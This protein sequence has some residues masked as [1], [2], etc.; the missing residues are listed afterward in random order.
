MADRGVS[1]MA[2]ALLRRPRRPGAAG[3]ARVRTWRSARSEA[4]WERLAPAS[5]D[6]RLLARRLVVS[7]NKTDPGAVAFDILRTRLLKVCRDNG[8][9]RV[10]ITSPTKGM[11]KSVICANLAFALARSEETRAVLLDLDLRM[12]GLKRIFGLRTPRPIAGLLRGEVPPEQFLERL[13]PAVAIGLNTTPVRHSSELLQ[14][15]AAR[16][17]LAAIEAT[18]EP[19]LMLFDLPPILVSDDAIAMLSQVD[20]ALLVAAAGETTAREVRDAEAMIAGVCSLIGVV[21]NKCRD[22]AAD[23]YRYYYG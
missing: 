10:A 11:G 8:W 23:G 21:L 18:Y 6:P 5:F 22:D 15:G 14:S 3:D 7:Q 4:A 16:E 2:R 17:A 9:R 13:G 1:A 12:P 19:D 20:A